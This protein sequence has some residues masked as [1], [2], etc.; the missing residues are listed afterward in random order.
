MGKSLLLI[1][2]LCPPPPRCVLVNVF[3]HGSTAG[4]NSK[5]TYFVSFG[6]LLRVTMTA[7]CAR[8]AR[9]LDPLVASPLPPSSL[10]FLPIYSLTS[11]RTRLTHTIEQKSVCKN[12]HCCFFFS[13]ETLTIIRFDSSDFSIACKWFVIKW[14]S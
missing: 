7:L 2:P 8:P 13:F 9:Q 11:A 5:D 4:R 12:S 1:P 10:S 3:F 6:R 14:Q